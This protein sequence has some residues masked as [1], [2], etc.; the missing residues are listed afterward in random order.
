MSQKK[1]L[2]FS[3]CLVLMYLYSR[4]LLYRTISCTGIRTYRTGVISVPPVNKRYA[5]VFYSSVCTGFLLPIYQTRILSVPKDKQL[6]VPAMQ[7]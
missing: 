4:M 7:I 6:L 2:R 3:S 5:D 1:R